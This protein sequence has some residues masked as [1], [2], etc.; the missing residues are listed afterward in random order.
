M[1]GAFFVDDADVYACLMRRAYARLNVVASV[2]NERLK[3]M[4]PAYEYHEFCEGVY[5]GNVPLQN[6]I[7][8]TEDYTPD[9]A[10]LSGMQTDWISGGTR[11]FQ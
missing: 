2:Y 1:F 9:Y 10:A 11:I 6:I 3:A 7:T 8:A 4:A 5:T